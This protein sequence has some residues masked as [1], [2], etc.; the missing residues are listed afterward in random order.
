MVVKIIILFMAI[1]TA[2]TMLGWLSLDTFMSLWQ[3][4]FVVGVK[5]ALFAMIPFGFALGFIVWLS[6]LKS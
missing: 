6:G 4:A 5:S 1:I 2:F 3:Q